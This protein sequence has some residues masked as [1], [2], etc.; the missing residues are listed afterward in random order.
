MAEEPEDKNEE[1]SE[2]TAAVDETAAESEAAESAPV[3]ELAAAA[4]SAQLVTPDV[5]FVR[6]IIAAGGSDLK[7]CYQCAQCA[8]VCNIT[9]DDRPFPRKEMMWAQWG[10]KDKLIGNP[11]IWLCHQC[12][13]CTAHCP[14]GAKPGQVMQAVGK[15]SLSHYSWPGFMGKLLGSAKSLLLLT[16]VPI[17]II[18]LLIAV[19]G[20][21]SPERGLPEEVREKD[22][23]AY[24]AVEGKIVYSRFLSLHAIDAAY[25]T[26]F[27]FAIFVLLAGSIRY[28]NDMKRNAVSNGLKMNG[29]FVSNIVPTIMEIVAHRR[30]R[31]CDTTKNRAVAHI[32][33]FYAF[34]GLFLTTI[35]SAFYTNFMGRYSPW[36]GGDPLKILG[37]TSA[38]AFLIGMTLVLIYRQRN[39][40]RAGAG[41]YYDWLFIVLIYLVGLSGVLTE[42][43]RATNVGAIAYPMYFVHL[44]SIMF[45]FLYAPYSKMAHM[46]YRAVAMVFGRSVDRNPAS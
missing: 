27:F 22:L 19:G 26:A 1:N 44:A 4:P 30:F 9:P 16:T 21:F 32:F 39:A 38:V 46:I 43:L 31:K 36:T 29:G 14:R 41:T 12:S 40:S 35:W 13:D 42:A 20:D 24:Q 11:D 15:M 37:N 28:W 17:A 34:I 2:E 45:L 6:Q 23:N 25:T 10:V 5:G 3:E 8:V 7:K 33:V 18:L